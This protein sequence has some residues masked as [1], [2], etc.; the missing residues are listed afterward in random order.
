MRGGETEI[1][2]GPDEW[3]PIF[4]WFQMYFWRFGEVRN[5]G[6]RPYHCKLALSNWE[7]L[8]HKYIWLTIQV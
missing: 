2:G 4:K 5:T 7:F 1:L 6:M 8:I 3:K